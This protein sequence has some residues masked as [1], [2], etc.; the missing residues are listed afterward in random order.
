MAL[1]AQSNQWLFWIAGF[2][3][4]LGALVLTV[5]Q[6]RWEGLRHLLQMKWR[7]QPFWY[8]IS[9]FGTPLV[10]AAALSL[11]VAL[12][13]DWP[14]YIDP[15]HLI[16]SWEEWPFVIL[17]FL[18]VFIFTALGEEIG[19]RGYA[20][21]RL[22]THFTPF[23]SS[24]ILGLVW[25]FWHLPLFWMAGNFHQQLPLVWFLLQVLGSTFL[26][27]WIFKHTGGSLLM[28]LFFHTSSN[29]AVGLLPVLP[30]DN[31]GSLRPLW[32]V[33]GLLW[34]VVGFVLWFERSSFFSHQKK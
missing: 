29:A 9:L 11:H 22:L 26:Y 6:S 23:T 8:F 7:V 31:G 30:L 17:V 12:G 1:T 14:R 13:A 25:A 15:Q 33:V 34:L 18:Y 32:L 19:W 3:P 2:G 27:T 4:T 24:L 5:I 20:L 16:T 21:P 10:I 28:A